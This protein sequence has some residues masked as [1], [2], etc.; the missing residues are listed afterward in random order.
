MRE[1]LKMPEVNGYSLEAP[2]VKAENI[3][4]QHGKSVREQ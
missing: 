3:V 2:Y 4:S 1:R